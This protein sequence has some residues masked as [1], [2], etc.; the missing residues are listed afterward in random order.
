MEGAHVVAAK[1]FLARIENAIL[2]PLMSLMMAAALLVFIWGG[3]QFIV[4]AD[5]EGG[6]DTGKKHMLY[7]IIGMFVM[8]SAFALLKLAASIFNITVSV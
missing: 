5:D 6:R 3:F 4:N 1:A 8:V 7:G 2:F